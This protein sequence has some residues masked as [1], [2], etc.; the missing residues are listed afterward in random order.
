MMRPLFP[1]A[2]IEGNTDCSN[3]DFHNEHFYDIPTFANLT[4]LLDSM[5]LVQRYSLEPLLTPHRFFYPRVVIDFYQTMNTLGERHPT[6]IHF[7][8]DGRQSIIRAADIVAAFLLLVA[9]ANSTDYR[10]WPHPSPLEMVRILSRDTSVGPI[11]FWRQLPT[12]MLFVDHV[13]RSNLFPLHHVFQRRGTILEA[14]YRISKGFW[15]NPPKLIMTSL[16]HFE[17]KIHIKHLRRAET[18]P[19]LFSRLLSHVL[20]HLGFPA[21]PHQEH[22]RVCEATFTVEKWHVVPGA[23]PLPSYPPAEVDPHIDP[24][25]VQMPPAAPA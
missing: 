25:Q 8:I 11:L 19:L 12:R 15:F 18:I 6:A 22:R 16:F 24:P 17:E 14:L 21:E 20:E 7:T 3:K 2:P 4:E 10:Q 9:L 13:L 5:G 1:C 23:P